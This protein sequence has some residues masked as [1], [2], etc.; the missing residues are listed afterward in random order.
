MPTTG[1]IRWARHDGRAVRGYPGQGVIVIEYQFEDGVQD[2]S[3]PRPGKPFYARGFPRQAFLP[4]SSQGQ[5]VLHMLITAFKRGLTFTIG[6]SVT[7]G[8]EDCL[9]WNGIHHKTGANGHGYPDM[10]YLDR[11]MQELKLFG[12]EG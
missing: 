6:R 11:V 10:A 1:K 5:R 9:T 8:E 3:Q 12:V 4:G 7:T 2:D